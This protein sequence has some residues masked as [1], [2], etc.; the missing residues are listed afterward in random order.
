MDRDGGGS[1][2][3][4]MPSH[5]MAMPLRARRRIPIAVPWALRR[6]MYNWHPGRAD[7]WRALPGLERVSGNR[8]VLTFDDGPGPDATPRV[9]EQLDRLGVG[10]TFFVLG[11]EVRRAPQ[12]AQRILAAGHELGL[13]GFSHPRYDLLSA[14]Q[15]RADLEQG[16][17]AIE[18]A[19]GVRPSWFR[20]PYGKLSDVSYEVCMSMGL[21]V[22]YW[23]AWGLD[24]EEIGARAIAGEV[25]SALEPGAV[26]LLH[27]TARYGRRTSARATAD[28]LAEIV[29]RGQQSGLAW[30]T[31]SGASDAAS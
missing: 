27:D 14:E 13:H 26:V 5:A 25:T 3:M 21:K 6:R 18:S 12:L 1:Q 20:P 10:A 30:T 31:I 19:A 8:A 2:M 23:S 24:W 29:R 16:L 11:A 22:A 15:A 7:R 9:L 4:T 17:E 28:A